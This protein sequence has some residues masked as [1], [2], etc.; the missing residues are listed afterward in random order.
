MT[1]SDK[2]AHLQ[3]IARHAL[4]IG[5]G[6]KPESPEKTQEIEGLAYAVALLVGRHDNVETVVDKARGYVKQPAGDEVLKMV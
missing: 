4:A 3:Q 5:A 6:L 2:E 1:E